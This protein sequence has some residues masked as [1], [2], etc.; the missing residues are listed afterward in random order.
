M[1]P[2]KYVQGF[3]S[4]ERDLSSS[5]NQRNFSYFLMLASVHNPVAR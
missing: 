3:Q 1:W 5:S 4:N 2:M